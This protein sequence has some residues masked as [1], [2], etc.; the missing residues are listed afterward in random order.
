MDKQIIEKYKKEMLEMYQRARPVISPI[1][2]TENSNTGGLIVSVTSIRGL[3]P[4]PDA[5]VTVFKG[6]PENRADIDSSMTDESGKS[7]LFLLPAPDIAYS[8]NSGSSEPVY[9]SYNIL[10]EADGFIDEINLNLPIFRG[11]TSLQ[12]VD[13]TLRSSTNGENVIINDQNENYNL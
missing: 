5:K 11:V 3:Y 12:N 6:S 9:T 1:E 8:Q 7:K 13:L 10:V 2:T 4:V